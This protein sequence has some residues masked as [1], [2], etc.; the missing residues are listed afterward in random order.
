M[1]ER[2]KY[3][4]IID[5]RVE[6]CCPGRHGV[7]RNVTQKEWREEIGPALRFF[8]ACGPKGVWA[9]KTSRGVFD[10]EF[11]HQAKV[12]PAPKKPWEWCGE[13]V[14]FKELQDAED[15]NREKG[16]NFKIGQKVK[17]SYKKVDYVGLIYAINKRASIV[18]E[19][20]G[21]F[22]MPFNSIKKV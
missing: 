18:V 4:K 3:S 20:D 7:V 10:I 17:F 12:F 11:C 21:I 5:A 14:L 9:T 2:E 15:R 8:Y 13:T 1:D 16:E 22:Y 6:W 19:N